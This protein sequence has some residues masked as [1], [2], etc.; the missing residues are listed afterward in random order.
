MAHKFDG[1][2]SAYIGP[3]GMVYDPTGL[4]YV[5]K[6]QPSRPQGYWTE[7][8]LAE[9]EL[10]DAAKRGVFTP[11]EYVKFVDPFGTVTIK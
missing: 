1:D 10:L 11:A 2:R 9:A 3:D 8:K 6:P 4:G 5:T 7:A